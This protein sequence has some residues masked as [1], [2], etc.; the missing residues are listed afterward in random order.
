MRVSG[1]GRIG[2]SLTIVAGVISAFVGAILV[3]LLLVAPAWGVC[4]EDVGVSPGFV[5]LFSVLPRLFGIGAGGFVVAFAIS[6][7][8]VRQGRFAIGLVVAALALMVGMTFFVPLLGE[9]S[10]FY[11][12]HHD[13]ATA[14]CGAE[15]VPTWWP[16]FLPH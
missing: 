13:G 15:G 9:S 1:S 12:T 6:R 7:R 4:G 8:V 14:A 3:T 2:L 11:Q 5:L 10:D 16:S